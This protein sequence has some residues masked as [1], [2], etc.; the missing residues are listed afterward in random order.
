M[1]RFALLLSMRCV[2]FVAYL[3]CDSQLWYQASGSFF[4]GDLDSS[5]LCGRESCPIC[6]RHIIYNAEQTC[7]FCGLHD[8]PDNTT[9][10]ESERL[11]KPRH[12]TEKESVNRYGQLADRI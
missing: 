3:A 9:V 1:R 4:P 8:D 2:E 11:A 7:E 10:R 12:V 5:W 6:G